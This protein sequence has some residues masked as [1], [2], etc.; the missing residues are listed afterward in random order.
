MKTDLGLLRIL[1]GLG[2]HKHGL[3]VLILSPLFFFLEMPLI[4]Q[5]SFGIQHV[6]A[7]LLVSSKLS[8]LKAPG[9]PQNKS[10]RW[11]PLLV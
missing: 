6:W 8:R 11:R 10:W 9:S 5:L 7:E 3:Q 4:P 2:V 1:P